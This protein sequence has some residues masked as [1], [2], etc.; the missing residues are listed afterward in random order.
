MFEFNIDKMLYNIPAGNHSIKEVTEILRSHPEVR[1]VSLV[2]IDIGGHDTDEKI[3]TKAFI[4]NMEEMFRHGVQT[5]GSSVVLPKIADLNN[6]K[7]DIIPDLDANW[8][9]DHNFR[10]MDLD[11][12][13]PVGTL[14]IPSHLLHNDTAEVGSRTVLR[15][16]VASFKKEL[17]RLL[18]EHPY[19]FDFLPFD[20]VDEIEDIILTSAMELEFWVRT[21]DIDADRREELSTAQLMQ[22]YSRLSARGSDSAHL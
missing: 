11:T 4:E 17:S 12:G 13:L 10:H 6:A 21:P 15:N 20:S 7:V 5:D 18:A 2:G 3:P 16:A 9:V 19:I 14:R 22:A 8:Y 1:F